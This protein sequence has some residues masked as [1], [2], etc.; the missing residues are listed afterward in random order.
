MAPNLTG[1]RLPRLIGISASAGRS[2]KSTIGDVL[3]RD[4]GYTILRMAQPIRDMFAA[5][6]LRAGLDRGTIDRCLNGDL[7]ETPLI[8][9]GGLSYRTFAE[10]IGTSWGRRSFSTALWVDLMRPRVRA[11]LREGRRVVID[12]IRFANEFSFIKQEWGGK[13]IRAERPDVTGRELDSLL[14]GFAFDHTIVN[15]KSLPWLVAKVHRMM[16]TL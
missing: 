9:L 16:E 10:G 2:G 8:S 7:K 1:L 11:E 14:D 12:D 15:D 5:F 6:A 3:H 13:M 4:Y